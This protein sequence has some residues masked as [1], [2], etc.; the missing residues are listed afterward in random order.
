MEMKIKIG[1]VLFAV[2]ITFSLLFFATTPLRAE[3]NRNLLPPWF[4]EAIRPIQEAI[5]RLVI[6]TDNHEQRIAEL[7]AKVTELQKEIDS[8]RPRQIDLGDVGTLQINTGGNGESGLIPT[9]TPTPTP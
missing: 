7:E 9:P 2:F 8:I 4:I 3:S 1:K 6:K 5:T